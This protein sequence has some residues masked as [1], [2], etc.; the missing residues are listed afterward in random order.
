M[1]EKKFA[2]LIRQE[3]KDDGSTQMMVKSEN[4]GIPD[5]EVILIVEAWLEKVKDHFKDKIM[6]DLDEKK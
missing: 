5:S 6:G 4:Q 2:L 1:M 3:K